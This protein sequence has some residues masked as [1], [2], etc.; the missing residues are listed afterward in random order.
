LAEVNHPH[1]ATISLVDNGAF[2]MVFALPIW[3]P[4]A[5]LGA[6]LLTCAVILAV[7]A[8]I[9][10]VAQ[11][12]WMHAKQVPSAPESERFGTLDTLFIESDSVRSGPDSSHGA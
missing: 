3:L 1:G 10:M 12:T 8:L 9:A 5:V 2:G 7:A 6:I 11:S 4:L